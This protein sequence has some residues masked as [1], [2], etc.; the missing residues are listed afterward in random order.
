MSTLDIRLPP[1]PPR[2]NAGC[3][4]PPARRPVMCSTG[5]L[6]GTGKCRFCRLLCYIQRLP[7]HGVIS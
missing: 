2:Q 4:T 6:F 3:I 7:V 5:P 1:P